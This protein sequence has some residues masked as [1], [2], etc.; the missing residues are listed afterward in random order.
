VQRGY[1]A[2]I[3]PGIP[4]DFNALLRNGIQIGTPWRQRQPL[5]TGI[6][7]ELVVGR[8][9]FLIPVMDQIV[10]GS[11]NLSVFVEA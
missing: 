4:P 9:E 2:V 6:I 7:Q 5:H 11:L 10:T 8:A 3:C 1:R